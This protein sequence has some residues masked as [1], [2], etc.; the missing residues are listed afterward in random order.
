MSAP[1][2]PY[3]LPCTRCSKLRY[4]RPD[5]LSGLCGAGDD[6]ARV[7]DMRTDEHRRSQAALESW[8]GV[9]TKAG[10]A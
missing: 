5:D 7:S 1:P 3:R 9:Q 10:A 8:L 2:L 4:L 6:D